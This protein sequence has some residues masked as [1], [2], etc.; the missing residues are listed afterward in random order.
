[1]EGT[2]EELMRNEEVRRA[3]IGA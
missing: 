1:M 3:Y 2:R